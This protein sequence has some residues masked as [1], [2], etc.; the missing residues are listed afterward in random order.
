MYI[1]PETYNPDELKGEDATLMR[2]YDL[3]VDDALGFLDTC[4]EDAETGVKAFDKLYR[5]VVAQVRER[6][7]Y[8]LE[9]CRLEHTADIMEADETH[10]KK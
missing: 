8:N 5:Q 9:G 10:W 4:A 1:D 3:A 6:L 7:E 2:G